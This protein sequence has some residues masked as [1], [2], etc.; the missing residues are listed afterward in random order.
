MYYIIPRYRSNTNTMPIAVPNHLLD[1]NPSHSQIHTPNASYR[2]PHKRHNF[3]PTNNIKSNQAHKTTWGNHKSMSIRVKRVQTQYEKTKKKEKKKRKKK[4]KKE[5]KEKK[6]D[7]E[8]KKKKEKNLNNHKP[9]FFQ[10]T[11]P[12]IAKPKKNYPK[13]CI[14]RSHIFKITT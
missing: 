6:N 3:I 4:E 8:K 9:K 11:A 7:K 13:E 2:M 1:P 14:P 12:T 5:K 10:T